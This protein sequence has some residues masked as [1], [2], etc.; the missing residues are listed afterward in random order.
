MTSTSI[1]Q[2]DIDDIPDLAD[3]AN[4]AGA[5]GD[6]GLSISLMDVVIA[7]IVNR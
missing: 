7:I 2:F 1:V 4:M 5:P 3:G 6:D